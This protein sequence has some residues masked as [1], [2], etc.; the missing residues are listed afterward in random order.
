MLAWAVD[1]VAASWL[2]KALRYVFRGVAELV[3]H[4]WHFDMAVY[5]RLGY[6]YQYML[7]IPDALQPFQQVQGV[8]TSATPLYPVNIGHHQD[9]SFGVVHQGYPIPRSANDRQ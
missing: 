7:I 8:G 4:H 5:S 1:C 2:E 6:H 9:P 3:L